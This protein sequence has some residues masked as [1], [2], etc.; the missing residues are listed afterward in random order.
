M[1]SPLAVRTLPPILALTLALTL[2]CAA[3]GQN[4][5]LELRGTT[6]PFVPVAGSVCTPVT[7]TPETLAVPSGA[8]ISA[9]VFGAP[10]QIYALGVATTLQCVTIPGI[11]NQLALAGSPVVIGGVLPPGGF[12]CSGTVSAA[13]IWNIAVPPA[14]PTGTQFVFQALTVA[15]GGTFAFTTP[16]VVATL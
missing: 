14:L 11:Q 12:I 9:H 6:G 16:V 13:S 7:C 4:V 2:A 10:G 8:T 3:S 15:S 5:G 1:K